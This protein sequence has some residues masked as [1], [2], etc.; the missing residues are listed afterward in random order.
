MKYD[1]WPMID[2]TLVYQLEVWVDLQ[3]KTAA[4]G[5]S[6]DANKAQTALQKYMGGTEVVTLLKQVMKHQRDEL[7]GSRTDDP[8]SARSDNKG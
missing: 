7:L 2:P 4:L 5:G 3:L 1:D 6:Q 8:K